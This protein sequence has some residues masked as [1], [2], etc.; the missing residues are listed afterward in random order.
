MV[1]R[2]STEPV[3]FEAPRLLSSDN[4]QHQ[5]S[6]S[7]NA[8][9]KDFMYQTTSQAL[10]EGVRASERSKLSQRMDKLTLQKEVLEGGRV[11]IKP[12]DV[13]QPHEFALSPED[14]VPPAQ[15]TRSIS[16]PRNEHPLYA[17]S[18]REIGVEKAQ[19]KVEIERKSRPN[20]FTNSFN[21]F[22]YRDFGLNTAITK[23]RICDHLDHS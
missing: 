11:K 4:Q 3:A 12:V 20:T 2:G 18:T 1:S 23:S 21:G 22:R 19:V 15:D 14:V 17:T 5:G 10:G 8:L 7:S 13:A 16:E 6:G 9:L